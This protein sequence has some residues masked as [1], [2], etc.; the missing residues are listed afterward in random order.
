MTTHSTAARPP[1][2]NIL[3]GD[4]L[5]RCFI[6][7]CEKVNYRRGDVWECCVTFLKVM[8]QRKGGSEGCQRVRSVWDTTKDKE[9][10]IC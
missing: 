5:E 7:V 9:R 6:T 10:M 4:H 2:S 8:H 3:Y 1:Q